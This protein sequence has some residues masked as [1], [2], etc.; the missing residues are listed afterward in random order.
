MSESR[1]PSAASDLRRR[2][3]ASVMQAGGERTIVPVANRV[4]HHH[5][6]VIDDATPFG[7]KPGTDGAFKQSNAF[8]QRV[9]QIDAT[10]CHIVAG[11]A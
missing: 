5:L 4:G 6:G 11:H 8:A 1:R 3:N 10:E 7:Q 9:N 2:I